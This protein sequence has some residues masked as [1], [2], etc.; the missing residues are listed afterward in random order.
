MLEPAILVAA[1]VSAGI[2]Q[3]FCRRAGAS[4][5]NQVSQPAVVGSPGSNTGFRSFR[6]FE[7]SL[8]FR[9]TYL[10]IFLKS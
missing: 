10:I 9:R 5:G 8:L 1:F 2:F 4:Q 3:V 7:F 6:A